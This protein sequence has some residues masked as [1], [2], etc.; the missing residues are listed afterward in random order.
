[1]VELNLMLL[2]GRRKTL[3]L[4]ETVVVGLN[5]GNNGKLVRWP[6]CSGA[7]IKSAIWALR[8]HAQLADKNTHSARVCNVIL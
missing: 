2:H 4:I 7:S 5:R 1:M 3:F 8:A 6:R